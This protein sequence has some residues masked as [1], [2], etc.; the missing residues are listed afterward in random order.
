MTQR[1]VSK[2]WA[3]LAIGIGTFTSVVVA[4]NVVVALPT[5]AE[6][7]GTDLPTVQWLLVGYTLTISALLLP[8]GRLSDIV[9][10]KRVYISGFVVFILGTIVSGSAPDVGTLIF[11]RII[12][13]A[14]SA[15]AQA[16]GMAMLISAFPSDERGT[17]LGAYVSVVGIASITG[18]AIGGLLVATLGWQWVFYIH[19]PLALIAIL[20][21]LL[22]LREQREARDAQRARFDWQGAVLSAGL[23][24][25]L[26]VAL[27][28]GP[29]T[30]W[31]SPPIVTAMV[32]FLALLGAFIWQEFH[33]PAP[34]LDLSL[35]KRPLFSLAIS[36]G[37]L[38]S[39]A[40][41]SSRFLMPFYLQNVLL[42]NVGKVGLIMVPNAV[43]IIV[44]GPLSG[45]LSDRYGWRNLNVGGMALMATGFFVLALIKENSHVGLAMAG[46]VIQ[47][48]GMGLF[49]SPNNSA[50][51]STVET[52]KYGVM[53]GLT[54][55]VRN[56]ANLTGVAV[57]TAIVT[58]TM[59]FKGHPPTLD[60][61]SDA[62]GAFTS[63]LRVTFLVMGAVAVVGMILSFVKSGR[64]GEG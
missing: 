8:I 20:V 40:L 16:T 32:G 15:M 60:A 63:A 7:F 29:T 47:N 45:R 12:Q 62:P 10:R 58:A 14:G 33:T 11:G 53:A 55:L 19:I 52:S 56:S 36:A 34:M 49:Q 38:S 39:L 30:G 51:L 28:L 61:V 17:A 27:S 23:L 42:F 4:A 37:F 22:V 13:G 54:Q 64:T 46:M 21:G 18:P 2:W 26:L 41:S 6:H 5:I 1:P 31:G 59:A 3:C 43:A 50:I 24:I 44:L 25:T 9:G 57:A 35:F 48:L